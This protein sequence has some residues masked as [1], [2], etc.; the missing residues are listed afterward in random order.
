M[1]RMAPMVDFAIH[2]RRRLCAVF[3]VGD[4]RG[5]ARLP[6]GWEALQPRAVIADPGEL[7]R[8][9]RLDKRAQLERLC[10]PGFKAIWR[11]DGSFFHPSWPPGS[12]RRGAVIAVA[13][14][15]A[16]VA[17]GIGALLLRG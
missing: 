16:A 3:M 11:E 5:R 10:P 17:A 8:W 7:D 4:E 6:A 15:V 14:G 12:G 2:R 1:A 13:I 9:V